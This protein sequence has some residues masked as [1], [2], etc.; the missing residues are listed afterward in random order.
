MTPLFVLLFLGGDK[1]VKKVELKKVMLS[2]E[3][4]VDPKVI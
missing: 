1:N 2:Y 4:M 3:M